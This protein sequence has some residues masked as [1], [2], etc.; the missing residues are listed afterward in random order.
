MAF[1]PSDNGKIALRFYECHGQKAAAKIENSLNLELLNI[2]DCLEREKE[3]KIDLDRLN[4]IKVEPWQIVT[5][6]LNRS[7]LIETYEK[8]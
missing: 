3:K 2:V 1:K 6:N 4:L 5:Y 8:K 7:N